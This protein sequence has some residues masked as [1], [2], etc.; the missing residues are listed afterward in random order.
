MT[1][2]EILRKLQGF[3]GAE[4]YLVGGYVRDLIR[5]KRNDDLDVV[6]RRLSPSRIK[7]FLGRYGNAKY[8]NLTF[9]VPIILFKA[10]GDKV[11][12]QITL[13]RDN[14]GN[15]RPGNTLE[16]D[17]ECRDFTINAM[18]LPIHHR[19]RKDIIDFF[20]GYKDIKRRLV[21]AVKDPNRRINESPIRMLRAISLAARTKYRIHKSLM[22]AIAENRDLIGLAPVEGIREELNKILLS[23]KPSTYLKV[24]QKIGLLKIVLPELDK[25]CG[26]RQDKKYHKFD[27]FKHCLYTCDYIEPDLI[28]RLAAVLHD[29][30]KPDTREIHGERT[31]FHKHEVVSARLAKVVLER[32]R[33]K[34]E[35]IS[36]TTHLIRMHMYHYTREFTDAAV[37]R[38]IKKVSIT[39]ENLDNIENIPLFKLRKAERKGNG[40]KTI[41]VTERQRDFERRIQRVFKGSKGFDIKDLDIDGTVIMRLFNMRPS[42]K[43]GETLE[44]MLEKV[45]EEPK[46]NTRKELV[47]LAAYYIYY[48]DVV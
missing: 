16:Q 39:K 6:V 31:T 25:C 46:L 27:V 20:G 40:F 37:R 23:N 35:T 11:E 45:L 32:L 48:K 33:Y 7:S 17:A 43:V 36:K 41:P 38:F 28:L 42:Q 4:V 1:T 24:M 2:M 13:P 21:R 9:G 15:F 34:K 5:R 26:V 30:G 3:H 19:S 22:H 44:Y 18:Y 14:K 29:I 12:A 47:K 8:A 10:F